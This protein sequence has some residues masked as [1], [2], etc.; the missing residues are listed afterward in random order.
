VLDADD[1]RCHVTRAGVNKPSYG[2]SFSQSTNSSANDAASV[3]ND[4]GVEN[5]KQLSSYTTGDG[6]LTT[7][8]SDANNT[9]Y[10]NL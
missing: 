4:M 8:L 9:V 5:A 10:N 3:P 1:I 6:Y 2:R 7:L